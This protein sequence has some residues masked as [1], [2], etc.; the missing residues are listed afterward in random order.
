VIFGFRGRP[1]RSPE[2]ATWLS[3]SRKKPAL[4]TPRYLANRETFL[5]SQICRQIDKNILHEKGIE[6]SPKA[7]PGIQDDSTSGHDQR[8][9]K[10]EIDERYPP[11]AVADPHF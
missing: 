4:V 1:G 2:E 3:E 8:F 10:T 9:F 11:P 6:S 5:L 7:K